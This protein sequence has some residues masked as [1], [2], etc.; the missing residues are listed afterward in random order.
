MYLRIQ[1]NNVYKEKNPVRYFLAAILD[2]VK[3]N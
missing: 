3:L 1:T 2:H